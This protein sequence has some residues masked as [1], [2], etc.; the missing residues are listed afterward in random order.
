MSETHNGGRVVIAG[1]GPGDPELLTVKAARRLQ[2][3]D[4]VLYDSL[5]TREILDLAAKGADMVPVGKRCGD[6]QD[7]TQRQNAINELMLDYACRGALCVRLKAGDPFVF[8]RGVEEVRFLTER[9][10]T[11]E[12]IPG[13]S[14]GIAAA[15]LFHVPVTE[16][17]RT[18]SVILSTGHTSTCSMEE[19][20]SVVALL[21]QG[22][23]LVLYMGMK[24]LECICQRLLD[25]GFSPDFPLCAAS[26][27]SMPDQQLIC[28]TLGTICLLLVKTPLP[29]PVVFFV[30]E[31]A[32]PISQQTV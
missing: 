4:A 31:H 22:T 7:Q 29:T 32:V 12:V 1:A 16:R 19:F 11:V 15:N 2:Q 26:R 21:K 13:I 10:V 14:A 8:G 27:V 30:G 5:V 24:H 25:A 17:Y 20:D 3:A 23:P 9:Q 6:G 18:S 28:A